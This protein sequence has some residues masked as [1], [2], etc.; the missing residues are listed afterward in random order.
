MTKDSLQYNAMV[1]DALRDVVRR[2][3]SEVAQ[4]G[5]PDNHHFYITFR[6]RHP[7]VQVPDYLRNRYPD[8]MT[9]VLQFQFHDLV[10]EEKSFG[11]T[12]SFNNKPEHLVIPFAAVTVFADPSV[13]FALSFQQAED[14]AAP[15]SEATPAA[16]APETADGKDKSGE[17]VSLDQFR[18]K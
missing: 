1:E 18:R 14:A 6:T 3:L 8:D 13:N 4:A 16:Q 11:V 7:G 10:V 12:L 2:A 17:V 9:I 15:A 5:L